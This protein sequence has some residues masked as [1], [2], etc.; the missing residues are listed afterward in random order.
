MVTRYSQFVANQVKIEIRIIS[1]T[2]LPATYGRLWKTEAEVL[3]PALEP[4][5][6][7]VNLSWWTGP[8]LSMA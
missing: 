3:S 2:W 1:L 5:L 8:G 6:E 4:A 7:A